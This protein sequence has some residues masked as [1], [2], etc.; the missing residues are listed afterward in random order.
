MRELGG[1]QREA[2]WAEAVVVARDGLLI[3]AWETDGML[4]RIGDEYRANPDGPE[5]FWADGLWETPEGKKRWEFSEAERTVGADPWAQ[6]F[7]PVNELLARMVAR[8]A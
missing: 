1:S 8:L 4:G 3:N 5:G 7:P 6:L 2:Y